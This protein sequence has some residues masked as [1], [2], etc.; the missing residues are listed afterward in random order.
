MGDRLPYLTPELLQGEVGLVLFALGIS[1]SIV[2]AFKPRLF[3][4][5]LLI[6]NILG[7]G[8]RVIGYIILDEVYTYFLIVGALLH[9]AMRRGAGNSER[10]AEPMMGVFVLLMGYLMLQSVIGMVVNEDWRIVRYALLYLM[11]GVLYWIV[12]RRG[13]DFPFPSHRR[14]LYILAVTTSFYLCMFVGQGIWGERVHG[15][16]GR[17]T[18]QEYIWAGSAAAVF[19]ILVGVP[20]A[21]MLLLRGA[22]LRDRVLAWL[23]ILAT[24]VAGFYFYSRMTWFVTITIL[25]TVLRRLSPFRVAFL[26]VFFFGA[27]CFWSDETMGD[28]LGDLFNTSQMMWAPSETDGKSRLLQL[29]AGFYTMSSDL[30]TFFIGNGFYSN[31]YMIVPGVREL[32]S[33]YPTWSDYVDT[34]FVG[35]IELEIVRTTGLPALM[36]DTGIVGLGLL[37]ANLLFIMQK[38][39]R[40]R[41]SV[42]MMLAMLPL[43]AVL[44]LCVSNTLDLV[45]FYIL[46]MPNGL[47]DRWSALTVEGDVPRRGPGERAWGSASISLPAPT[48]EGCE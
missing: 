15:P 6:V 28:L 29:S 48:A 25:A 32:L 26:A 37:A 12:Q 34:A 39:L 42:A 21:G 9:I 23:T 10:A 38:V 35:D 22:L 36:I 41:S 27:F 40:S 46:L 18:P 33:K 4:P 47:L 17:F 16:L 5:F 24:M 43:M 3:W 13:G 11:M 14:L 7:A 30:R 20:A 2:V 44:W 1:L 45:L 8:P 19:P 31:R